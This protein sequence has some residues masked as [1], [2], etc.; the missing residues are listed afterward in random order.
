M[1]G[2]KIK[3]IKAANF[4]SNN[5]VYWS[6]F[7]VYEIP[8]GG[9]GQKKKREHVDLN[10]EQQLILNRLKAWRKERADS[11]G[12]PV[13]LI[14]TNR[15]LFDI[16]LRRPATPEGLKMI[17]G[18]GE[19]K[20]EKYGKEI[21]NL[22]GA[23]NEK[24]GP[25]HHNAVGKGYKPSIVT[26]HYC[27]EEVVFKIERELK[28]GKY[29][30]GNYH[31]FVVKDPKLRLISVPPVRDRVV[32]H[33]L[34]NIIGPIFEKSLIDHSYACREGKGTHAALRYALG[35]A[36]KNR[37][38]LK[39]DIRSYFLSIDRSRLFALICRKIKDPDVLWL[40]RNIIYQGQV[41]GAHSGKGIPIGNL[42][43]QLFAN[44]YLNPLDHWIKEKLRVE[45]YLR[46]MDDLL[47]FSR[48]KDD[49]FGALYEIH[50]YLQKELLLEL[51]EK[52]TVIA[53]LSQGIPFL[54]FRIFPGLI[55]LNRAGKKRFMKKCRSRQKQ[56]STGLLMESEYV[57][58]MNSLVAFISTADSYRFRRNFFKGEQ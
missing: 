38:F 10:D 48:T 37:F 1:T 39:T 6:I 36:R 43:S 23:E 49:L 11:E 45:Y 13:Y 25:S 33:A 12:F 52:A 20:V 7:M 5:R 17:E 31:H 58:S 16:V 8:G 19:K 34:C 42:T 40:V 35:C 18:I 4:R 22:I 27:M 14:A 28:G 15:Q 51:K 46:Y 56:F 26:L 55:R 47:L 29:V 30:L 44:L 9:D 41:P 32:H 3:S 54:G 50:T 53:P 2:K 57:N 24:P 21:L